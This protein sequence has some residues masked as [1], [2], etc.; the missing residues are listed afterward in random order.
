MHGMLH[1]LFTIHDINYILSEMLKVFILN[2]SGVLTQKI[3]ILNM[4][5]CQDQKI[6]QMATMGYFCHKPLTQ[7]GATKQKVALEIEFLNWFFANASPHIK[8]SPTPTIK[9]KQLTQ[10]ETAKTTNLIN[11]E[12]NVRNINGG[13]E[14]RLHIRN[15]NARGFIV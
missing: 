12:D 7:K 15:I 5:S 10:N 2:S 9:D 14:K 3:Q 11:L 6:Y 13:N 8:L 1:F 4:E